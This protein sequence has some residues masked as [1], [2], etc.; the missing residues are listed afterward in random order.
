M[1]VCIFDAYTSNYATIGWR[2]ILS[3]APPGQKF[4]PNQM[5]PDLLGRWRLVKVVI[6]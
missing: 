3:C 1:R 4:V 2:R 6:Q 5:Q